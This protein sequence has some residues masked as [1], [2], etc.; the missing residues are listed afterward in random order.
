MTRAPRL[1]PVTRFLRRP[2]W[3]AAGVGL[4]G[5]LLLG[6]DVRAV[7][8]QD[9]RFADAVEVDARPSPGW[10]G[11]TPVVPLDYQ[12][13]DTGEAVTA[14]AFVRNTAFVPEPG[15]TV[16]IRAS[17]RD[18]TAVQLVD[19]ERGVTDELPL[20]LGGVAL[21][22]AFWVVRRV[23]IGRVERLV[24]EPATSFAMLGAV[25]PPTLV[26]RRWRLLLYPVDAAVGT[27]PVCAVALVAVPG[28]PSGVF[29]VE[30]KG[31]PRALGRVVARAGDDLLWPRGRAAPRAVWP[32][33]A[34]LGALRPDLVRVPGGPVVAAAAPSPW[35]ARLLT[36]TGVALLGAALW[37]NADALRTQQQAVE[38]S[39][40]VA[41]V[42]QAP[43][44]DATGDQPVVVQFPWAG[45]LA[46]ARWRGAR[47]PALS[48]GATVT[49]RYDPG[50]PTTVWASDDELPPATD[51][52]QMIALLLVVAFPGPL[53]LGAGAR[54]R[55]RVV[56]GARELLTAGRIIDG[57]PPTASVGL[58]V[59]DGALMVRAHDA[60][61]WRDGL[62]SRPAATFTAD[63]VVLHD[64]DGDHLHA[65]DEHAAAED[66]DTGATRWR[67]DASTGNSR[68]SRH[69]DLVVES[70][71]RTTGPSGTEPATTV[72][73]RL[74]V[75]GLVGSADIEALSH[76][77][78]ATPAAR[79]ALADPTRT[80]TVLAGLLGRARGTDPGAS[81]ARSRVLTVLDPP[82]GRG[83][84]GPG[85]AV[86]P[87][88]A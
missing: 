61:T 82:A 86:D 55:V 53:V 70:T 72:V 21:A 18:P 71:L 42:V 75:A 46:T 77:L 52:A 19:D 76:H 62:L 16:R 29:P 51:G 44:A 81:R 60:S 17:R 80:I 35:P 11:G 38:R 78:A 88:P 64:D 31:A 74:P 25:A 83:R 58:T 32:R 65:W 12:R 14:T 15:A 37:A 43:P 20:Y 22:L 67:W 48:P 56:T 24:S 87:D 73:G 54:H 84:D 3:W 23:H 34:A 47:V 49:V 30:V 57:W 66:D 45:G 27:E 68:R 50:D 69:L 79:A 5:L 28:A 59:W 4:L 6:T 39:R 36:A 2:L 7:R 33:P 10:N 1:A 13:P 63:G 85:V 26:H 41:A 8:E 40:L 9:A